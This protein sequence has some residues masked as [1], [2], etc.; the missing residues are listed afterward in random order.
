LRLWW[1][2]KRA[3]AVFTD[4][5]KDRKDDASVII[6]WKQN[7]TS[8]I[9]TELARLATDEQVVAVYVREDI[10]FNGKKSSEDACV[11]DVSRCTFWGYFAATE[12]KTVKEK[13]DKVNNELRSFTTELYGRKPTQQEEQLSRFRIVTQYKIRSEF[14]INNA[15]LKQQV[16]EN[17]TANYK[18]RTV[19]QKECDGQLHMGF[20]I[21][22]QS[23][24]MSIETCITHSII[25]DL[26]L[27]MV[28]GLSIAATKQAK[29]GVIETNAY[30]EDIE[31]E[32]EDTS[33]SD[34]DLVANFLISL[35]LSCATYAE[36]LDCAML[37]NYAGALCWMHHIQTKPGD[38][39]KT[40]VKPLE[41][42]ELP[43][44]LCNHPHS[45]SSRLLDVNIHFLLQIAHDSGIFAKTN[46]NQKGERVKFSDALIQDIVNLVFQATM[47]RFT[48]RVKHFKTY[49]Q[50][51]DS[52]PMVPTPEQVGIFL[53]FMKTTLRGTANN[54]QL[55]GQW[56]SSQHKNCIP[57]STQSYVDFSRFAT[58]LAKQLPEV[59]HTML[60]GKGQLDA[61]V[62]L[63][64]LSLELSRQ[65][66][67][68]D[69]HWMAQ[70]IVA[71]V[72]DI[73]KDVFG[74]PTDG[75]VQLGF[76]ARMGLVL[77]Q[78]ANEDMIKPTPVTTLNKIVLMVQAEKLL[79][80]YLHILGLER[81]VLEG[82][83]VVVHKMN[84]RPFNVTAAEDFLCRIY[85]AA[86]VTFGAYSNSAN[87]RFG[88]HSA[89]Q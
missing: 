33:N 63:R 79:I 8:K 13:L 17:H 46:T 56:L 64:T 68:C 27:Q 38:V 21:G 85:S 6:P 54:R 14:L 4:Y 39:T 2:T 12:S 3:G 49:L 34:S 44:G 58:G 81:K 28:S 67:N 37:V 31:D 75:S 55:A 7:L 5:S 24:V 69:L 43:V 22:S 70:Q 89:T 35:A 78:K 71:D 83:S 25:G 32:E 45:L 84:G 41:I 74:A 87:P 52:L 36:A 48:G 10:M 26:F 42:W 1:F 9:N 51:T 16:I 61:L 18:V 53:R 47:L 23:T 40:R 15:Q 60:K 65:E 76:G 88:K 62:T 72:D 29:K 30:T 20:S 82:N 59:V 66:S 73:F 80:N 86:K 57:K 77:I 50:L 11:T 19:K